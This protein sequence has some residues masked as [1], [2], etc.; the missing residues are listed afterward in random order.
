MFKFI[1]RWFDSAEEADVWEKLPGEKNTLSVECSHLKKFNM[2]DLRWQQDKKEKTL[3]RRGKCQS[4]NG[5]LIINYK[6][7]SKEEAWS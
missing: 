7:L 6:K 4:C 2:H 1:K 3:E 5:E